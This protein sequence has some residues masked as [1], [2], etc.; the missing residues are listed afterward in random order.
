[1]ES[2][3]LLRFFILILCYYKDDPKEISNYNNVK[4]I[5]LITM[6]PF[7]DDMLICRRIFKVLRELKNMMN[8]KYQNLS[9]SHLSMETSNDFEMVIEEGLNIVRIGATIFE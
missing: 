1:M 9:I 4:I 2:I 3:I 6:P 7:K 8:K 5:G